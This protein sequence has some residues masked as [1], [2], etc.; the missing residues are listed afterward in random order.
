MCRGWQHKAAEVY[1]GP[2]TVADGFRKI[3]FPVLCFSMSADP[4]TP[5]SAA[6]S[7]SRGFGN[8]SATLVIQNG[9]GHC[10][11]AHPS[12]CS[13]KIARAYFLEGVVPEYG[14]MCD[15][16]PGFLFL[17]PGEP[18]LSSLSAADSKLSK[19]SEALHSLSNEVHRL[20][21]RPPFAT[22]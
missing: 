11:I 16:D 10:S 15:A 21:M 2:W 1:R 22:A 8:E 5:L 20:A 12:L 13:A 3:N 9:F 14:T 18:S 7:M 17:H 6:K 4:V 19:L